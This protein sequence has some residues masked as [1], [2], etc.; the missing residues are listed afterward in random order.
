MENRPTAEHRVWSLA[1]CSQSQARELCWPLS[2]REQMLLETLSI[3]QQ[4]WCQ[5]WNARVELARIVL[6]GGRRWRRAGGSLLWLPDP[7]LNQKVYG[8]FG[9]PAVGIQKRQIEISWE[10][11]GGWNTGVRRVWVSTPPY[12]QSPSPPAS[13][14]Q[15]EPVQPDL[16]L[17]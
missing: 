6:Q 1:G 14:F 10:K 17:W 2:I 16:Y 13:S 5:G 15:P 3:S 4:E 8:G 11:K 9:R 7:L 12:P